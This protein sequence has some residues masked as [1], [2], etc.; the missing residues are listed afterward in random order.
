MKVKMLE[1]EYEGKNSTRYCLCCD[2]FTTFEYDWK[3]I[4]SVCENCGNQYGVNKDNNVLKHFLKRLR[5]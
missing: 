2:E 5:S 1:K 4:H 3:I